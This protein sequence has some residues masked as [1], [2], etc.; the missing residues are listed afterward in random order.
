MFPDEKFASGPYPGDK[1]VYKSKTVVEYATPPR[2]EGLGTY[3]GL[4]KSESP[5]D[6]VAILIEQRTPD[7]LLLS[8]RLSPSSNGTVSTI[9]HQVERD[10][11]RHPERLRLRPFKPLDVRR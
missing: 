8:V 11:E 10:T 1:L 2:N 4:K 7:L 9:V 6:G 5:T 3:W